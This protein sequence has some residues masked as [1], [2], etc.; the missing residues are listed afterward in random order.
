MAKAISEL[1]NLRKL[2]NEVVVV[3]MICGNDKEVA[4]EITLRHFCLVEAPAIVI[5]LLLFGTTL[6]M[7]S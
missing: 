6:A 2:F 3:D 7:F 1:Q 4:K 5:G